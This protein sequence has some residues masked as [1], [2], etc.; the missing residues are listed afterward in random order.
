MG[1][2][3]LALLIPSSHACGGVRRDPDRLLL[4]SLLALGLSRGAAASRHRAPAP[5]DADPQALRLSGRGAEDRGRAPAHAAAG[6]AALPSGGAR[7]LAHLSRYAAG[8][9]AEALSAGDAGRSRLEQIRRLD[10]DR[11]AG[12]RPRRLPPVACPAAR[13]V[14]R[15][16]RHLAPASAPGRRR[17]ERLRWRQDGGGREERARAG[18]LSA[19]LGRGGDARRLR[20]ADLRHRG[21]AVLGPGPARFRRSPTRRYP[22]P[23]RSAKARSFLMEALGLPSRNVNLALR[24]NE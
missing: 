11:G 3:I 9:R 16:A 20:G 19:V 10:G 13:A 6:A 7:S 24:L 2:A 18:A 17:R 1:P 8:A 12:W 22:R 23:R 15:G 5:R 4:Q 14:G 21:R